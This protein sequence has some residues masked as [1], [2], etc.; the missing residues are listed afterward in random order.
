LPPIELGGKHFNRMDKKTFFVLASSMLISLLGFGIVVPLLPIYADQMGASALEIGLINA[1]FGLMIL[2]ALPFM[3]RLSDRFGRKVFLC[4]GLALLTVT[5][6]GFIWAQNPTQLILV[7]IA[8]GIGASMHLPIAQAYLGDIT[9][10]GEEGKWMGHFNAILLSGM[11]LGPLFGGAITDLFSATTTFLVMSALCF[12]GLIATLLFLPEVAHRVV[13]E[14]QGS[15]FDGLRKSRIMKGVFI[16]RMTIGLNM[17]CIMAFLPLFGSQNL[18][19]SVF[20]IGVLIAA[21]TPLAL[22]QSYTGTL[23]DRYNR[24]G[25]IAIGS[26]TA[27]I[28]TVLIP[29]TGGFWTLLVMFALMS[30]GIAFVMPAATAYVVE[31]GRVFGMGASMA[32]FMVAMQIGNGF[33]PIMLGGIVDSMGIEAAF[34]AT[35]VLLVLGVAAFSWF[36]RGYKPRVIETT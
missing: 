18:G 6:L 16:L 11:S 23:S 10:K 27:I 15:I 29:L 4:I 17:A 3:G 21:R 25:L 33:G 20:L 8:Q 28:F 24:R 31:E 14:R 9:P 34:Y 7:R 26:I 36:S 32:L 30:I 35:A 1:G 2:V 22:L 5:S 19:L 12:I 13:A